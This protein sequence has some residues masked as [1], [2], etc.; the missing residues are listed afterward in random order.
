MT[1]KELKSEY[2]L[3]SEET[4]HVDV[5]LMMM[6]DNPDGIWAMCEDA[7]IHLEFDDI[8]DLCEQYKQESL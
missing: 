4:G 3:T 5:L 8:A 1:L 6:P 7:D 2:G